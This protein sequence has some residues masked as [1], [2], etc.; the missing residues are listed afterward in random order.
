MIMAQVHT[1][2]NLS[3]FVSA[4]PRISSYCSISAYGID[5]D[6]VQKVFPSDPMHFGSGPCTPNIL[7][8]WQGSCRPSFTWVEEVSL[9]CQQTMPDHSIPHFWTLRDIYLCSGI[10]GVGVR[11]HAAYSS[12]YQVSYLDYPLLQN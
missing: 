11:K 7:S 3:C 6:T 2:G 9:R 10:F 4:N 1:F 8:L 12:A 5:P